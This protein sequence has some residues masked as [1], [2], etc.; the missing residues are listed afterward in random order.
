VLHMLQCNPLVVAAREGS[1]G[2]QRRMGLGGGADT[3]CGRV[4]T[5]AAS[6]QL[7]CTRG[8]RSGTSNT[9]FEY[10]CPI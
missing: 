7:E 3:V 9:D 6:S 10:L 1:G 2:A 5:Y 4:G 8:R